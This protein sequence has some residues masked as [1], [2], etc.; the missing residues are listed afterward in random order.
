MCL[1]HIWVALH[2]KP[3]AQY[4]NESTSFQVSRLNHASAIV[5]LSYQL[6][7][8]DSSVACRNDKGHWYVKKGAWDAIGQVRVAVQLNLQACSMVQAGDSKAHAQEG[9]MKI[10][11]LLKLHNHVARMAAN[12]GRQLTSIIGHF[13]AVLLQLR[14]AW[15]AVRAVHAQCGGCDQ[16]LA[17]LSLETW[18]VSGQRK[19][20]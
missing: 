17:S 20:L 2:A 16:Y 3:L 15:S 7:L 19:L 11:R 10:G 13:A 1:H 6:C 4:Q 9:R 12:V 8:S 14:I 18:V 5:S